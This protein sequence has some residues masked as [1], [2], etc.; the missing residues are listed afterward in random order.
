MS[1]AALPRTGRRSHPLLRPQTAGVFYALFIIPIVF[2]LL[3]N[4][5]DHPGYLT[6]ANAANVLD[7]AAMDGILVVFMTIVLTTGNFDLSIA[8]TAAL[9]SMMMLR[10]VDTMD[11]TLVVI[12]CL[13]MGAV[14]G[15]VN[16]VLVQYVKINAFIVTLATQTVI[17]GIVFVATGATS[18]VSDSDS[19]TTLTLGSYDAD[20]A[21]LVATLAGLAAILS[22]AQ[23]VRGNK[24]LQ[25]AALRVAVCFAVG[26]GAMLLLPRTFS[27]TKQVI[28][29]IVITLAAWVVMRYTVVGR[30]IY[31]VGSNPEAAE[32]AGVSV[33]RYR[34]GAFVASGIAA[35][36]VGILFAGRFQSMNPQALQGEELVVLTAAILGGT[37]LF[38][39]VGDVI[40][41][42]T[43]ALI[44]AALANGMNIQNID[45]SYQYVIQ[46]TVLV[47]AAGVYTV[48]L[49]RP[50]RRRTVDDPEGGAP[51]G[52]GGAVPAD[53]DG[54]GSE[55]A[56]AG[57]PNERSGR[58][59]E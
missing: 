44:L 33:N 7:Q 42:V 29:L 5:T 1:A 51:P 39:G 53:A 4:A 49:R 37:S 50:S 59:T 54:G 2:G 25:A 28:M 32:L 22:V 24:T 15:I 17:R 40:K 57:V 55:P 52:A 14:V 21:L 19:L 36:F 10:L 23:A 58:L 12:L 48:A 45:S 11:I 26:V 8:S 20:L 9:S 43:G 18:V 41:S 35:A 47:I 56:S 16:G 31:A 34:I 30:R 3:T 27:F 6:S 46:G 38:G 13:G